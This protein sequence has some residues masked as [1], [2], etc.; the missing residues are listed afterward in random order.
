[1]VEQ[2]L[3]REV[4]GLVDRGYGGDDPGMNATGYVEI[5]PHLRGERP[6][7]AALELIR[8]NTRAY[9]RRQLT[10]FR[11]QLPAGAV[12]LDATR[13]REEL[14]EEVTREWVRVGSLNG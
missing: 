7:D 14:A 5:L 6:L 3:L 13:P 8:R 2:G 1:M 10:W 9:A 11:H 4:R 12:W